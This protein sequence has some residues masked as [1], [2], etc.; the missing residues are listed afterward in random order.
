MNTKPITNEQAERKLLL[1]AS[2]EVVDSLVELEKKF[3]E[4]NHKKRIKKSF[5]N[6]ETNQEYFLK[7]Q[8]QNPLTANDKSWINSMGLRRGLFR[9]IKQWISG[10]EFWHT[11]VGNIEEK[12]E[13]ERGIR[14]VNMKTISAVNELELEEFL[15]LVHSIGSQKKFSPSKKVVRTYCLMGNSA[16]S[17]RFF[18]DLISLSQG[19]KRFSYQDPM[20]L[21][22]VARTPLR[23]YFAST[24]NKL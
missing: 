10:E 20:K 4:A 11:L 6:I 21:Q 19:C 17:A 14:R 7:K 15:M 3:L 24:I 13:S 12:P 16:T 18:K 9:L 22:L 2:V 23:E 5:F 1:E 8:Y